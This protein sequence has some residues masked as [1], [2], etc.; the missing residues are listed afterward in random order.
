MREVVRTADQAGLGRAVVVRREGR[1]L[2]RRALS[3]LPIV[4]VV[5]F[6][7]MP[8]KKEDCE[9]LLTLMITKRAPEEYASLNLYGVAW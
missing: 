9:L 3:S 8:P 2:I 1:V 7:I 5:I 4:S 6:P